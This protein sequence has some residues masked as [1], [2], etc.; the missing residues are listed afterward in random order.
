V[1]MQ[2]RG[3]S[4]GMRGPEGPRPAPDFSAALATWQ[5]ARETGTVGLRMEE[6]GRFCAAAPTT[7]ATNCIE[8]RQLDVRDGQEEGICAS[9]ALKRVSRN[10]S[11]ALAH[12][13]LP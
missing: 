12:V 4:R 2:I 13:G 1:D 9:R 3:P 11:A 7:Q 10:D 5:L 6:L 8:S